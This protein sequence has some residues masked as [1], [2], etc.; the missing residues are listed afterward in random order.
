[1]LTVSFQ[2]FGPLFRLVQKTSVEVSF[3]SHDSYTERLDIIYFDLERDA[4]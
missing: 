3:L 2:G 1:M 4:G